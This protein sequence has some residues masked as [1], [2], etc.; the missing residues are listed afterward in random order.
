M[1]AAIHENHLFLATLGPLAASLSRVENSNQNVIP[2]RAIWYYQLAD[3]L[4]S[5]M[6]NLL[7]YMPWGG[8]LRHMFGTKITIYAEHVVEQYDCFHSLFACVVLYYSC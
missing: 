4:P 5:S 3:T 1:G 7:L 8:L 6:Q 2:E